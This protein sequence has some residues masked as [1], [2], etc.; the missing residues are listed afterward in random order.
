M[1]IVIIRMKSSALVCLIVVFRDREL[2]ADTVE[3]VFVSDIAHKVLGFLEVRQHVLS[4]G[5]T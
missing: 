5:K 2:P 3:L 4:Q 1:S